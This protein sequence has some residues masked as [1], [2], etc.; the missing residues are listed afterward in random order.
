MSDQW[1]SKPAL[2]RAVQIPVSALNLHDCVLSAFV[3]QQD[4]TNDQGTAKKSCQTLGPIRRPRTSVSTNTHECIG[5][6]TVLAQ[7]LQNPKRWVNPAIFGSS[8]RASV[9]LVHD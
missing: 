7:I 9:Q 3:M 1:K 4:E 5:G 2:A 8:G 6:T